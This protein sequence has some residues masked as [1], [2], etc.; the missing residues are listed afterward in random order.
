MPSPDD[1]ITVTMTR[2][3]ALALQKVAELG[4]RAAETFNLVASTMT[5]ERGLNALRQGTAAVTAEKRS[6]KGE[7]RARA[8]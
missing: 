3:E 4:L 1:K 8:H 7:D 6:A 5:A 2:R